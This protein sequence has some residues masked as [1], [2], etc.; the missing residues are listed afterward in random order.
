MIHKNKTDSA[1]TTK[2]S[3]QLID[4]EGFVDVVEFS[5]FK[6]RT[7]LSQTTTENQEAVYD[8][9]FLAWNYLTVSIHDPS[10]GDLTQNL[11]RRCKHLASRSRNRS[12]VV[13]IV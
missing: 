10:T 12:P 11:S 6:S 13:Y 5:W 9:F 2:N 7:D 8:H 1:D 4:I 3:I